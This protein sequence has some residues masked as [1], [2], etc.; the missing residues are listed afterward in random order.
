M[1]APAAP[2]NGEPSNTISPA[3]SVSA[4]A[5]DTLMAAV[6]SAVGNEVRGWVPGVS[7]AT[8]TG[9]AEGLT[10]AMSPPALFVPERGAGKAKWIA[11]S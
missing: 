5:A 4:T 1:R 9:A 6:A 10:L 8:P 7:D 3:A 11:R 2:P